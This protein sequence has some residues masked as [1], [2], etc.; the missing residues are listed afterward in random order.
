[1]TKTIVVLETIISLSGYYSSADGLTGYNLIVELRNILQSTY[2][3]KNYD[4]SKEY[5]RDIDT[6]PNNPNNLIEFYTGDSVP[7]AWDSGVT[8]NIEHVWPQSLLGVSAGAVNAASD[9]HNLKPANPSINSSRGNKFFDVSTT[10]ISYYPTR[11][12]IHGDIA[13]MLFY[14]VIMYNIY[15]LVDTT[16]ATFEMGKLSVLLQ[17]HLDDPVD[18]FER[19]RNNRIQYHQGN[20]N[21]FIDYPELIFYLDISQA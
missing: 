1:M 4:Y 8:Y 7:G 13:R 16:P 17:W 14:M 20:R 21:P 18:D 10:T 5:I 15:S 11:T 6:D 19:Y 9:L 3:G 12:A 2:S